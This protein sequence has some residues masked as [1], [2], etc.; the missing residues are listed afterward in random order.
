[1][2]DYPPQMRHGVV[3]VQD[4]TRY[5]ASRATGVDC[6]FQGNGC[7]VS[8]Y[9]DVYATAQEKMASRLTSLYDAGWGRV[10]GEK[11]LQYMQNCPPRDVVTCSAFDNFRV[12]NCT[13]LCVFCY[14]QRRTVVPFKRME[15]VIYGD[16]AADPDAKP[17]RDDLRV[18]A[19]CVRIDGEKAR[20][21]P[22]G[23]PTRKQVV[24]FRPLLRDRRNKESAG[25]FAECGTVAYQVRSDAKYRRLRAYRQGVLLARQEPMPQTIA[26]F[27]ENAGMYE[28]FPATKSG[29]RDAFRFAMK[30][31]ADILDEPAKPLA[32]VLTGFEGFK[33][34]TWVGDPVDTS[35]AFPEG[36]E[37]TI[38]AAKRAS[39]PKVKLSRNR[40]GFNLDV[41]Y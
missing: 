23:M 17:V 15:V 26:K 4:A 36:G 24:G 9:R 38:A 14:A 1:M 3:R 18:L 25:W 5:H 40:G 16:S 6:L 12:C 11:R 31:D 20:E 32:A 10:R 34:Q 22:D 28:S 21:W 8:H 39:A 37:E 13:Q 29:L 2:S 33:Y 35:V 27:R 41:R 19:F 30:Y 7:S